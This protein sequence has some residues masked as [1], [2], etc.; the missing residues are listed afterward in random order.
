MRITTTK[1]LRLIY[2]ISLL[3][4]GLHLNA[5]SR[6]VEVAG[7]VTDVQGAVVPQASVTATNE[8]TGVKLSTAASCHQSDPET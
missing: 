4:G 7:V 6:R 1:I 5:Q 3:T 2:G 8:A